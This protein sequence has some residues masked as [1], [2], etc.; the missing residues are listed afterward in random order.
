MIFLGM[1]LGAA[2]G[3]GLVFGT[4]FMNQSFLDIEDAKD[5]LELPVLGGISRITTQEEIDKEKY[6]KKKFITITLVSSIV[7]IVIALLI[8]FL[9][10]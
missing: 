2:I 9:K 6:T 5:S 8:S 4:E 1:T 7:L 3:A 10:R